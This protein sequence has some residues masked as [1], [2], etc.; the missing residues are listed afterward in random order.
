MGWNNPPVR[1]RE[2]ERALSGKPVE[3]NPDNGGGVAA[4]PERI[5]GA[6]RHDAHIK[7]GRQRVQLWRT[8]RATLC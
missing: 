5:F 2:L 7:E 6:R 4:K 3:Q 8:V 1:W